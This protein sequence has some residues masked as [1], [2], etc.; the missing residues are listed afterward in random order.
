MNLFHRRHL[1]LF[2]ALF[3]AA[4]LGGCFLASSPKLILGIVGAS[5]A[6]ILVGI[7]IFARKYRARLLK[8]SLCFLFAAIALFQSYIAFDRVRNKIDPY[9]GET[10]TVTIS[11][12]SK[13]VISDFFSSFE[14]LISTPET[15]FKAILEC[16]YKTDVKVG[17]TLEG[18]VLIDTIESAY[19]D[20]YYYYADGIFAVA[21]SSEDNLSEIGHHSSAV[22]AFVN[23][24]NRE[25]SYVIE[26]SVGGQA[27]DLTSAMFLGNRH[28]LD[29]EIQRDFSRIGLSH[30]LA[31]SG[32][33]LSVI[34]LLLEWILKKLS[35]KK[36]WRGII[37]L[38]FALFYL[39]LTGFALSTI[40]AFIMMAF[41]CLAFLLSKDN[42]PVTSLFFAL[43][44]IFVIFPTAVLDVGIW[45]SFLALLGI[46]TAEYFKNALAD[47]LY[48]TGLNKRIVKIL[49]AL[50][51]A[52]L[53]SFAANIFVCLPIWLTFKELALLSVPANLILAP[54]SSV[55][56][57][58][59]PLL[60]ILHLIP[61]LSFAVPIVATAIRW[62]CRI[63]LDIASFLSHLENITISLHYPFVPFLLIPASIA[64][65]VLL[66]VPLR[67][68]RWLVVVP[69]TT[70]LLFG[71]MLILH[72]AMHRDVTTVDYLSFGESEMLI[73]TTNHEAIICDFSTGSNSYLYEAVELCKTRYNTEIDALVLTHY[74]TLHISTFSKNAARSMIR[75]LYLPYPETEEEYHIMKS[76]LV[77]AE[78]KKVAVTVY[79][80]NE[81]FSPCES[82]DL[83]ISPIVYLKRSTH[84]TFAAALSS[85]GK[86]VVYIAESAHEDLALKN[87]VSQL[88]EDAD[89]MI[90]GTH[91]PVTKSDYSYCSSVKSPYFIISSKDVF[92]HAKNLQKDAQLLLNVKSVTLKLV[93][94]ED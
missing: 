9:I 13:S 36:G 64:L 41:V 22:S 58:L 51:A 14:A 48:Q 92:D 40:R 3:A 81:S 46:F 42:D 88:T 80:R 6:L 4:S 2:C 71:G 72:N 30:V 32:M 65:A 66:I 16:E 45:M 18:K 50:L 79:N 60:L 78:K 57:F 93:G 35:V 67:R 1:A 52:I 69:V 75:H 77:T 20:A 33:H 17:D 43:F 31:L 86:K 44:L 37:V 56:L 84:P 11:I 23:S 26:F 21:V 73:A 70:A 54:L 39:Y 34:M 7:L 29:R 90:L 19:E 76:L 38:A 28:L 12:I 83:T 10:E 91:G 87:E 74:H 24:L 62:L 94:E 82:V 68:K 55:L 49:L 5:V 27:A 61:F 85:F 25:L 59:A 15:S 8:I 47:K 89:F 63:I 53:I